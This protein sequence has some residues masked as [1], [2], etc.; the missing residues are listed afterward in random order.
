MSVVLITGCSSGFGLLTAARLAAGGHA[1]YA[2][3]RDLSRK[4]QLLEEVEKR[5]GNVHLLQMDVT[6]DGSI[7]SAANQIA[8][9]QGKLHGLINNAGYGIGG[10]FE[11]LTEEEI[12][13]QME[14]NF[15]GVQKVS[16]AF[17]PLM[18]RTA[19]YAGEPPVQIINISSPQGRSPYPGMSAYAASKWALEGFSESLYFELKPFG[20]SVVVLEPGAHWTPGFAENARRAE[21][22][23]DPE[24]PYSPLVKFL[25]K[26]RQRIMETGF[27]VGDPEDVATFIQKIID[28]PNPRFRYVIGRV[29]KLRLFLRDLLPFRWFSSLLLRVVFGRGGRFSPQVPDQRAR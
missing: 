12:R 10:F 11:D 23:G 7:S 14:T 4:E 19:S 24:S 26:R 5:G 20:I 2:T 8:E 22:T 6:H 27:G 29:A 13:N 28:D 25:E 15:F 1:V 18:R 17:L 3:M 21:R 9:E 16:R